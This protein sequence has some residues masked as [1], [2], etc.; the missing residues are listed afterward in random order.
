M[1]R[2]KTS[3]LVKTVP[4]SALLFFVFSLLFSPLYLSNAW[5][6]HP[7]KEGGISH[8]HPAQADDIEAGKVSQPDAHHSFEDAEL[9]SKRFDAPGRKDWQKPVEVI[10]LMEIEP[11]MTVADIGAG[12]GYFLGY[13]SNTVGVHGTVLGLDVEPTMVDF[14]TDRAKREGW[15]NV[16]VRTDRILIVNT[17]HHID[18]RESYSRKLYAA[19]TPGGEILVVDFTH[20][21][22]H[23]PPVSQ[24][25]RPEEVMAELQAGGLDVEILKESLPDQYIVVGRR[26]QE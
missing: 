1:I 14:M 24:R 8:R 9:W 12:T 23:G 25:L 16:E 4:G 18:N 19:L 22:S 13:L 2:S 10:E 15:S 11:G 7:P 20:Q 5:S 3:S 6:Q 21:S 26:P 17:W